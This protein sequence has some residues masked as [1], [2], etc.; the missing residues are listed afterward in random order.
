MAADMSFLIAD[1]D[2]YAPLDT[3]DPGPRYHAGPLPAGWLR[4]ETGIWTYWEP[5]AAVLADSGWKV[6]VASSFANAQFVLAVV[7]AVC[8]EF[9]VPFK[10]LTGRRSFLILHGKHA[11]RVQAGKF[12]ALYPSTRDSAELLLRRLAEELSGIS[13][14]YVLTD[15][16]FG[17][18]EC[19]SYRYG[20]FQRRLQ[21]DAEGYPVHI[22]AGP[23]GQLIEDKREPRFVLPAG[24]S[25]PFR[26]EASTPAARGPVVLR[27]YTYEKVLQ[28]SNAGGA[29]RFTSDQGEPVFIKEAKSHNG[30]TDDG[31]DAKGR[32]NAECL[33]LRAIHGR[34]PG[35]CPKPIELFEYQRSYPRS[36]RGR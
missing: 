33:T 5:E 14:P 20:G 34:A 10:H 9:G 22:V 19:V 32:L 21:V 3:V 12:C 29:Y 28:H 4:R 1:R 7:S 16:R 11:A 26:A 25:D 36:R 15:R 23:D 8:A 17:D 31:A 35:L 18:S 24:M 27:G 6:H 30:Y 13:G 2:F